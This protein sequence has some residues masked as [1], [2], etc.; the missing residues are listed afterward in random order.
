MKRT[1]GVFC[2]PWLA[3]AFM[4]SPAL[5]V[6]EL[7]Q[8][9][10]DEGYGAGYTSGY[11]SG[12]PVGEERGVT[13][14]TSQGNSQGYTA[15]WD[16]AYQPAYDLAY[17]MQFPLGAEEGYAVGLLDGFDAGYDWAEEQANYYSGVLAVNGA[18]LDWYGGVYGGYLSVNFLTGISIR[19]LG[20]YDGS[21]SGTLTMSITPL[22]YDWA[23][24]YYDEGFTDG[25]GI[26]YSAGDLAGYDAAYPTAFAAA[27]ETGRLAGF[28][29][30]GAEGTSLGGLA[31]FDAGWDAGYAQGEPIGF[32]AGVEYFLY[33]D[34][35][36]PPQLNV[37]E[38]NLDV[39]E[40]STLLLAGLALAIGRRRF[41]TR[42][43]A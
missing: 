21:S 42:F 9:N 40:P 5:G 19:D 24:H 25:K 23:A 18:V 32:D 39:P 35:T 41:A 34:F 27:F 20:G 4:V 26:G 3:A 15:G 1:T 29:E 37:A 7:Y 2:L 13:E 38:L 16:E 36:P 8:P 12:F 6:P 22:E 10:Y 31:G 17:T 11:D 30:G 28:D 33:G 14:G 43:A